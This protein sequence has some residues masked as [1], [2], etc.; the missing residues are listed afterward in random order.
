MKLILSSCDFRNEKSKKTIIDNLSKPIEQCKLLF[1]PNEKAT[2]EAIHSEKYYF[3]MQEFGFTRLNIK[4]FDYYNAQQ[5]IDLDLDVIY[6]SGG[7]TFATLKRIKDCGFDKEIIRYVKS[8]V[9]YIGGSAG[10]HIA[11]QSIEHIAAFDSIPDGMSEFKGLGLFDGILICHYTAERK[12]L[13]D[14][15][16]SNSKYKVYALSDD[17]SLVV[18]SITDDVIQHYDL[19]V[20]ENNDPVHDPKSLQ[21]YMDKWDG[22]IF[23]DKMGLNKENKVLEIGVG[24]GRVAVRVAPLCSK[25]VG[26]DISPKTI[27]R[28]KENLKYF[29][30]ITLICDDFLKHYFSEA[31]DVIYSSLTFMHIEEKQ[32]AINKVATLLNDGGKFVLSIDKNQDRFIDTGTRKIA[33]FPDTPQNTVPYI[34]NAGLKLIEQFET[35]FAHIFVAEKRP[36]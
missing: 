10:A 29:G 5:F 8:G 1:F 9:L 27:V 7:N 33:V 14:D 28:A 17:D 22:Q 21:D 13:L 24:T 34:A 30:N 2:Y 6:I 31:F 35:E 36:T 26:I 18:N 12:R 25:F 11:T 32:T 4:V 16:I 3:R 20:K 23:I 15:L 19:L